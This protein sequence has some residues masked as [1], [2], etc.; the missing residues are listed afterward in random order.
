MKVRSFLTAAQR[1]AVMVVGLTSFCALEVTGTWMPEP[2]RTAMRVGVPWEAKSIREWFRDEK[3]R[4]LLNRLSELGVEIKLPKQPAD[5]GALPFAG[6]TFVLTGELVS[7]TR[8]AAKSMIKQYGGS[9][10]GSVSKKTDFV[11]AGENPGSKLDVAKK[12]GVTVLDETEFKK[13]VT[14]N[15]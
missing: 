9:V 8:E 4:S 10:T 12:L 6:K 3:H 1:E 15:W 13:M 5:V 2:R 7:F 14:S 11:V